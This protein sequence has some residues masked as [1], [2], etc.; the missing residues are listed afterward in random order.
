MTSQGFVPLYQRLFNHYREKILR[1]EYSPGDRI[2][3]ITRIMERHS[4]S[5]ETAKIVLSRLNEEGYI[6]KKAGKG[7][8][9]T[10]ARE[11]EKVWG[12]V[13]PF[14]SSN[15]DDLIGNLH[16]EAQNVKREIRYVFHY[17]E[18]E[19][20]MR[21]VGSMIRDGYEAIM[22]VPN[23]DESLTADFYRSLN[24]GSTMIVLLDN[25]MVGSFF[26]Y[27]IQSYDLGVKR[28]FNYLSVQN[29]KNLLFVK[30]E[31][32]RG[33]NLVHE[34]MEQSLQYFMH[35]QCPGKELKVV[36][37]LR[38]LDYEYFRDNN[39]GGVLCC[40]DSDA[41]RLTGSLVKYEMKIPE[42]VSLVCY[43]NTELTLSGPVPLTVVDCKYPEIASTAASL[44]FCKECTRQTQQFVIEP[45]L[46]IRGT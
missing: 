23:Y 12:I 27:A 30:D 35:K 10:Y 16:H 36:S 37:G 19:E 9:V 1:Q 7:S 39:I 21:Q 29:D 28:A 26:N 14:M 11:L 13:V 2:D 3:S 42:E 40:T 24:P 33:K 20:E 44:I 46:L 4:V 45:E 18:P 31:T 22:I 17:N 34:L 38:Q 15:I 32:W 8:F 41:V 43:G 5:R 25:T 6:I